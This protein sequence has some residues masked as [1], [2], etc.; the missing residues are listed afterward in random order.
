MRQF[1]LGLI[2]AAAAW[3]G[4]DKWMT[5]SP[6]HAS[7]SGGSAT[8]GD[9]RVPSEADGIGAGSLGQLLNGGSGSPGPG[10]N[11]APANDQEA[12]IESDLAADAGAASSAIGGVNTGGDLDAD[13]AQ[14]LPRIA[15]GDKSAI[16][17]AWG[18]VASGHLGV[19][20]DRVVSAIAPRGVDFSSQLAALGNNNAFLHSSAG[21]A[22]AAKVLKVAVQ[23]RDDEA[24]KAGSQLVSL[25]TRGRIDRSDNAARAVVDQAYRQHRIRVDR[26]LCNPT[27]VAGARTYTVQ[28]GNSLDVI[29]RKF[30]R[31][32]IKIEA[33]T[34]AM[35]N[36]IS[37]P[38]LLRVGQ[39]LKIPVAAV[40]AVL[41]KRSYALTVFVGDE[42]LRLYW[43]GHGEHDRTPVTEFTVIAK[44]EK[45]EWTAPDGNIYAYGRPENILGEYFIKFG[46]D[47][48]S[49]FGAHGTPMP[50][51]ICTMSSMGCIRM[52]DA[53]IAEL[54]KILPRGAKVIVRASN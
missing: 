12:H 32:G 14:L 30:R 3:W 45:P 49:G 43:V 42:L 44:Q 52:F 5:G 46:H 7:G 6:A 50:E 31:Q 35:L 20:H 41:E 48:Y 51:T 4:Y 40:S 53:D 16:S 39:K 11:V 15:A 27:N 24:V 19:E 47:Q 8:Q 9:G 34:I 33:G 18:V 26:W 23:L 13:L 37:N 1:V 2:L 21:R 17:L 10:S 54:F 36:R 22:A 25:M 38:N 28:S 29:A